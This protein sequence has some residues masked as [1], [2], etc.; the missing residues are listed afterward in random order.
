MRAGDR[1]A[2]AEFLRRYDSRIRRR[3]RGKLGPSMRR[4]FDS[5]DIVS[6]LGRRLD[7]YV[8]S[9]RLRAV[10]GDQLWSLIMTMAEHAV[11]DK[12]RIVKRLQSVEAED[13]PFAQLFIHR[14]HEAELLGSD[15]PDIEIARLLEALE[16]PVDREVLTLWLSGSN[17]VQTA[18]TLGMAP[19]AIRKRWQS[20]KA[21][22]RAHIEESASS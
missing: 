14:V 10:S 18:E 6:T 20:I 22:L 19:T 1:D 3:I 8:Q 11:I 13:A 21:Q 9:G 2:A 15:G 7:L 5:H 4:L 12:S 17:H 16:D